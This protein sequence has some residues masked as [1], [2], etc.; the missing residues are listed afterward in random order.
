MFFVFFLQ[1]NQVIHQQ[2]TSKKIKDLRKFLTQWAN[3]CSKSATYPLLSF[4]FTLNM[5][6][7]ADKTITINKLTRSKYMSKVS[8]KDVF[9]VGLGI[10]K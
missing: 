1:G 7:S 4:L 6:L 8:N 5:Y 10:Y 3:S 9:I 2:A